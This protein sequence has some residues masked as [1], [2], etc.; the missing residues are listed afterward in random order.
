MMH[1]YSVPAVILDKEPLRDFDSRITFY[2]EKFGK[3]SGKATSTRKITSKL[4]AHLEPGNMVNMRFVEKHGL[5]IVDTLRTRKIRASLPEL[6]ALNQ[7]L[8]EGEPDPE[9]WT[10]LKS[11]KFRWTDILRILGWDPAHGSCAS[12][13]SLPQSFYLSRQEMY[14]TACASKLPVAQVIYF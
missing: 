1:E 14:C 10:H 3:L 13:G 6:Y 11:A 8:G 2:T 9:L 4:S 7:L 12:C 5:Q